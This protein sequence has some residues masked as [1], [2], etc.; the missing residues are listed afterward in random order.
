[1]AAE[2]AGP[3]QAAPAR[4]R[5]ANQDYSACDLFLAAEMFCSCPLKCG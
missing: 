2:A 3:A 4:H 5:R 1:M